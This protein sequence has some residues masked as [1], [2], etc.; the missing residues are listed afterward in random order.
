MRDTKSLGSTRQN[1]LDAAIDA[2]LAEIDSGSYRATSAT[3]LSDFSWFLREQRGIESID[4]IEVIDVRRYSQW[5]RE[6]ADDDSDSLSS[7]SA[8]DSGPYWL[9]VRAFLGW[10]VDDER[11]DSNPAQ[12]NRAQDP[13]PE[14][15]S[16]PNRQYWSEDARES[17]LSYVDERARAALEVE[18]EDDVQSEDESVEAAT[19][20]D[21]ADVDRE[22]AFRD[23]ALVEMLALTGVRG[24]EIVAD[25]RDDQRNGLNWDDVSLQDGVA[26]VFGKSREYQDVPLI[27]RVV[28]VLERHK[29]SMKP[30]SDEW[31]I[32][33]TGH[34]PSLSAT[35]RE[36]LQ[37]RGWDDDE[38]EDVI[39]ENEWLDICREYDITPPA[40]SKN[41]ARSVLKRL[42]E[43]ADVNVDG[44]YLKPHGG[45]RGLGSE[46]YAKD[47]ELTQELLRHQSIETT[48]ES[49]REE[50]TK[51]NRE[52]VDQILSD[53]TS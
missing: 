51:E 19:D 33:V 17:L 14:N 6:R 13:L 29:K 8:C 7:A 52:R 4:D 12:P 39:D 42:S 35:V 38:I 27:D 48:H 11:L 53:D 26:S 2:R 31:P 34:Y 37:E 18:A 15:T 50:R 23:R 43:E 41:G 20:A 3:V 5:L 40:L 36:A 30:S 47:A 25:P 49:Y 10:C 28:S 9:C 21:H 44:E 22:Q 16:E 32:F 24:A 1:S 46:L 45:R